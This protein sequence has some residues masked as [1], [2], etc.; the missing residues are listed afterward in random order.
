MN[1]K[2]LPILG[3]F[4]SVLDVPA[5][6]KNTGTHS[7][8]LFTVLSLVCRCRIHCWHQVAAGGICSSGE[9]LA[10]CCVSRFWSF[11]LEGLG[12]SCPLSSFPSGGHHTQKL[13]HPMPSGALWCQM[14]SCLGCV[15]SDFKVYEREKGCQ[16]TYLLVI[17]LSVLWPHPVLVS[18][19][20]GV[21]F[22]TWIIGK[23][24]ST[25][26]DMHEGKGLWLPGKG[27]RFFCF[28]KYLRDYNSV[29]RL[30]TEYWKKNH[31][32][33]CTLLHF[34]A[35]TMGECCV[36]GQ[37][38]FRRAGEH[39]CGTSAPRQGG[40]KGVSGAGGCFLEAE[41]KVFPLTNHL[42]A[43]FFME[44]ILLLFHSSMV[45]IFEFRNWSL[46][47]SHLP[48]PFQAGFAVTTTVY[49]VLGCQELTLDVCEHFG[50][51]SE[52]LILM[53]DKPRIIRRI[54]PW[55]F[56]FLWITFVWCFDS[57]LHRWPHAEIK[58]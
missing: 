34:Q 17:N 56:Y 2:I 35:E 48:A 20:L 9:L 31:Y 54:T 37:K 30:C 7:V 28:F 44:V 52:L 3:N 18:F 41:V 4:F 49:I 5:C 6:G 8:S 29:H 36:V 53:W 26:I 15:F 11:R 40:E 24:T 45:I 13:L 23:I 42:K 25:V 38:T 19:G 12:P 51:M 16:R 43:S 32:R 1:F 33:L 39:R 21:F 14:C 55:L 58:N 50:L 57:S 46:T 22:L 10:M 27:H 47:S